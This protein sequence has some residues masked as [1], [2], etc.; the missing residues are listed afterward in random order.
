MFGIPNVPTPTN[1]QI[2]RPLC[3]TTHTKYK[4]MKTEQ[5]LNSQ[6]TINLQKV[7]A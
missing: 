2:V 1:P 6:N 5:I 4:L 3:P 7:G